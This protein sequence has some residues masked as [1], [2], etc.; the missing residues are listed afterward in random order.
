MTRSTSDGL[1]G[2]ICL[3]YSLHYQAK[4]IEYY[5]GGLRLV[6]LHVIPGRAQLL[7][8]PPFKGIEACILMQSCRRASK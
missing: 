5:V 3:E 8:A 6:A 4:G 2:A 1:V 7:H